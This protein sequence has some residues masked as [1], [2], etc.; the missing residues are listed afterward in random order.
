MAEV[1]LEWA[2]VFT[3]L[4]QVSGIAVAQGADVGGSLDA[5]GL[6]GQAEGPLEGRAVYRLGRGRSPLQG[7]QGQVVSEAV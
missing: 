2:P 7:Q 4:E 3:L 5:A 6:E 1:D